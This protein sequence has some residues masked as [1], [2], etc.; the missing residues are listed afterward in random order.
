MSLSKRV[1]GQTTELVGAQTFQVERLRD[2]ALSPQPDASDFWEQ[3][4][5][6]DRSVTATH[7]TLQSLD[8]KIALLATA[9]ER[10]TGGDP[11]ALDTQWQSIRSEANALNEAL[12]GNQA[13]NV[14]WERTQP[15]VRSRLSKIMTGLSGN[16]YGPTQTAR[17]QF[18]YA[19]SEFGTIRERTRILS[20]RTI[21]ALEAELI[22][23]GAPW[24]PGGAIP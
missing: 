13:R 21:P 24:I 3:I 19:Q 8:S 15:T 2:G 12:N 1:R 10:V 9:L 16:T 17:T 14:L 6:F 4:A 18:A 7:A 11:V 23:A 22:A 20:D 5:E